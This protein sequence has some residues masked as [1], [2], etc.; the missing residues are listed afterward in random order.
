[1]SAAPAVNSKGASSGNEGK[2]A[3]KAYIVSPVRIFVGNRT[4]RLARKRST[5][6]LSRDAPTERVQYSVTQSNKHFARLV[7]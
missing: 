1:M 5:I 2:R 7:R 6:G 3:C 4:Y